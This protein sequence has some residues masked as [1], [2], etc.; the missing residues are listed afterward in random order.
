[1][2]KIISI[3]LAVLVVSSATAIAQKRF[4]L[5][6]KAGLTANWL[7][8]TIKPVSQ[9][10]VAGSSDFKM[11]MAPNF[12]AGLSA[13]YEFI[14]DFI[15]QLEAL[16]VG[17]GGAYRHYLAGFND[18]TTWTHKYEVSL[19][20]VQVPLFFGYRF[21]DDQVSIMIGPEFGFNLFAKNKTTY[22]TAF[23]DPVIS[24]QK[25]NPLREDIKS[26]VRPFNVALALQASY[27]FW[28]GLCLDAKV[29]WGLNR[30]FTSDSAS[31]DK[32]DFNARLNILTVQIGLSYKFAL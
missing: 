11:L 21:M 6:P 4:R 19:G 30:T 26:Y 7:T 14:D 22:N 10:P 2:K 13:E 17:K 23:P 31:F 24:E 9:M 27:M 28:E 20:Y 1:M 25:P 16:Y 8:G 12:Y 3:L 15:L 32:I 5:G 29:S 18:N